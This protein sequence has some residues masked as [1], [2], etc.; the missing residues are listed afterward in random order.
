MKKQ[1]VTLKKEKNSNVLSCTWARKK[2]KQNKVAALVARPTATLPGVRTL[3]S[4]RISSP[5]VV[6]MAGAAV[7]RVTFRVVSLGID[8]AVGVASAQPRT[9]PGFVV[10]DRRLLH[11][12]APAPAAKSG[13]PENWRKKILRAVF[14]DLYIR[15]NRDEL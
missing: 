15:S 6:V 4:R 11:S 8:G 9:S 2:N 3:L 7:V 13:A 1:K 14:L 5:E 12:M 10:V